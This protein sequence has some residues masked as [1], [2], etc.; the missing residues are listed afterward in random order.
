M[1]E[2]I[3]IEYKNIA[4]T[5]TRYP[6]IVA[7][8]V[9]AII[10][11]I[12]YC[13]LREGFP[14]GCYAAI[15]RGVVYH[16][17]LNPECAGA[18]QNRGDGFTRDLAGVEVHNDDAEIHPGIESYSKEGR[19]T[20]NSITFRLIYLKGNTQALTTFCFSCGMRTL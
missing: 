6:L 10:P 7:P 12:D 1:H 2:R 8:S 18:R 16:D 15:G 9:A 13:N 19:S 5:R 11:C 20:I 3:G 17:D 4:A 14:E